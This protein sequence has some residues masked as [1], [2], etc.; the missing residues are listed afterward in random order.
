MKKLLY[1]II[2]VFLCSISTAAQ[3]FEIVQGD[4][5]NR[6]DENNLKQGFWKIFGRMKRLPGYEP[7]QVV[8][9]GNYKNSRKMGLW[10]RFFPNGKVKDEITYVNSRPSG[11]YK[12]YYDNGQVQEEGSWKNNRNTGEFKRYH[13]NGQVAQSFKFN[14]SGK[15]EGKQQYFYENGQ[16][17]IEGDWA[18]G[19][20][21]GV[22]TEYY[23]DGSLKAK[24]AFADGKLDPVK[25]E[26][27]EPKTP[28]KDK[29]EEELAKAPVKVVKISKDEKANM[30]SFNGNG[31]KKMYNSNR[32]ISK[33]G[34]FK[35]YRLMDGKWYKYD[36]NGLLIAIEI[37]KKGKYIGDAPIP[38][39]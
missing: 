31:Y 15:R 5:I 27:F 22:I 1:I 21:A 29:N 10:K 9:E 26:V 18:G 14:T 37:Y 12:T 16:V 4:T 33:D 23:E 7:D 28:I 6:I 20:E 8:E 24:K 32:Q 35:N 36:E 30:G 11:Y 17:M 39:D 34:V 13:E 19:K 38:N 25:T 2:P 3:S